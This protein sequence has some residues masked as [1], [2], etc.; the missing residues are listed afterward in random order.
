MFLADISDVLEVCAM[1]LGALGLAFIQ[2][3]FKAILEQC[4]LVVDLGVTIPFDTL[5]LAQ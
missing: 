3:G 1:C 2:Q 4:V 5:E